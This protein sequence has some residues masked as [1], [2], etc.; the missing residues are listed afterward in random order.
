MNRELAR[1][2]P[3]DVVL[4]TN[5][6]INLP[7]HEII[8][9]STQ[10]EVLDEVHRLA[11]NGEIGAAYTLAETPAG[12]AVKVVRIR[13]R[14]RSGFRWALIM[15]LLLSAGLTLLAAWLLINALIPV[16]PFLTL[17]AV[18]W[19]LLARTHKRASSV[20]I[21]QSVHFRHRA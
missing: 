7:R 1:K 10:R 9:R 8:V 5:S 6:N 3:A 2:R 13:E 18:T 19:L 15:A 12:Y 20:T 11:R 4:K 21:N 17:V 14:G 16:L